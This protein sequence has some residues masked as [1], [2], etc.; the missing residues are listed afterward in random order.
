MVPASGSKQYGSRSS[1][2]APGESSL[3]DLTESFRQY[4]RSVRSPQSPQTHQDH[5]LEFFHSLRN[6]EITPTKD[7][8]ERQQRIIEKRKEDHRLKQ[9]RENARL[10]GPFA[11]ISDDPSGVESEPWKQNYREAIASARSS[12]SSPNVQPFPEHLRN[13]LRSPT[14]NYFLKF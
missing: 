7:F 5:E 11:G 6:H 1:A 9:Q 13:R 8:L 10:S 4:R 3:L 2:A 12:Y 14:G